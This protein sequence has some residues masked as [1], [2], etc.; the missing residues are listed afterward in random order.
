MLGITRA[1]ESVRGR[2]VVAAACNC[3]RS[4]SACVMSQQ[5]VEQPGVGGQKT[6]HSRHIGIAGA[7][8]ELSKMESGD[9]QQG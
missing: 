9:M 8:I 7:R 4:R 6:P 5:A 2:F 1:T 3:A